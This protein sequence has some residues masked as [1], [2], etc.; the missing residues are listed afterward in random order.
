MQRIATSTKAVDLYG[1]GKHGFK[2]GNLTLGI[3]PTDLEASWCNGVQEELVNLI[4]VAGLVASGATLNQIVQAIAILQRQQTNTAFTTTGVAPNFVLTPSLP[5]T[6]Y[7]A[8]Q[9]FRVNFN[10]A[11]SG[12]NA[13][14]VSALGAKLLKQYD[15]SG[16]KVAAVIAVGQLADIE[17]DGVDFV[18]LDPLPAVS[19]QVPVR[20][21][22]LSGPVDT[23]GS[24]T[25]LPSTSASLNITSQNVSTGV[26]V[27][28]ATA[29]G[30]VNANGAINVVGQATTNLTWT[31]CTA[32]QTNYLPVSILGGVLTTLTPVTLAPIYQWGGTPAVTAGRYTYNIQQGVM[33]LGNGSVANAVN[34]VIVGEV[35]AGAST[36]TST[37]AYAYQGRYD[38][39][40]FAI[41]ANTLFAK[42]HNLGVPPAYF[43]SWGGDAGLLNTGEWAYTVAALSANGGAWLAN[44]DLP[45]AISLA[46]DSPVRFVT[47]SATVTY[48]AATQ[49][50][51]I[52]QRGW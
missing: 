44:V 24:A 10:A 36:I 42:S 41:S 40:W 31:G 49:A 11:G 38:S 5:V 39:G 52:A 50:R 37:R 46:T 19:I 7:A 28:V 47:N 27:L 13:I 34:H 45:N 14:N 51:I 22:V 1:V 16:A 2:D 3:T 48:V 30:G 33:W 29:A 15:A 6:A 23:N 20:Q 43:K 12:A 18:I 25:F 32:N 26:N 9:R 17:Y 8:N 35:V 21:T 4:E